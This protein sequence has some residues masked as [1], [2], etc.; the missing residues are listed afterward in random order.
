MRNYLSGAA[1]FFG[2]LALVPACVG[3]VSAWSA[4]NGFLLF[5]L[6]IPVATLVLLVGGTLRAIS[7][8]KLARQTA[9]AGERLGLVLVAPV[10]MVLVVL[11][12]LPLLSAGNF[13]GNSARLAFNMGD[14]EAIISKAR[15]SH[16]PALAKSSA[17]RRSSTEPA[18]SSPGRV[19]Q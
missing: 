11:L 1:K 3:F 10:G 19:P 8:V 18:G 9:N 5:L 6:G 14:Y 16:K 4:G 13:I 2:F 7:G 12:S 17:A 15:A